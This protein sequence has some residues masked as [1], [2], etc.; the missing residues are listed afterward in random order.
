MYGTGVLSGHALVTV[1]P[2][3]M[4]GFQAATQSAAGE[5]A[6]PILWL[7]YSKAPAQGVSV[8]RRCVKVVT[9]QQAP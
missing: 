1:V 8:Y 9:V 4:F 6:Q 7:Q 2:P 5:A 3:K